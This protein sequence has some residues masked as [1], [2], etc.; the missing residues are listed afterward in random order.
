MRVRIR[1]PLPVSR[2][3]M[4]RARSLTRLLRVQPPFALARSLAHSLARSQVRVDF[5]KLS[6]LA[7]EAGGAASGVDA[8]EAV[9]SHVVLATEL[10]EM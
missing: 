9:L 1:F 3:L 4:R 8:S 2:S 7:C 5:D 10:F 6:F